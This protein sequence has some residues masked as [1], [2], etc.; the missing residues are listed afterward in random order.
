MTS[1]F[2][3]RITNKMTD[4]SI[5]IVSYRGWTRLTGCLDSLKSLAGAGFRY[6]VIIVDNH[7][8]EDIIHKIE[9]Q[10]PD[11]RF[12]HNRINGGYANGNNLGGKNATGQYLLVLNPDTVITASS[13]ERLLE[14]AWSNPDY[15]IISCR[16]VNETG[17]E[18]RA[19]GQF[20]RFRNMTGFQRSILALITRKTDRNHSG[21]SVSYPDW[22]SGSVILIKREL[23]I[24]MGGF[25][26]GYWM[27]FED[28]ELCKRVFD[29]GG[30]IAFLNDV[31]I[32]H[33]HGGSSRINL[34][35]ASITKTEVLV[36][37][38]VY[39]SRNLKGAEREFIQIFLVINNLISGAVMAITGIVLFFIP[40]VFIRT[41]IYGRL[42]GYYI[43][44]LFRGSWLSRRAVRSLNTHN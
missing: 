21:S 28:M 17:K 26:E 20:L 23:Y 14:T 12:I 27:Y 9:K 43:G 30:R 32:E 31:T 13:V 15:S 36:S 34:L 25:F 1:G 10:Y 37:R 33:N 44:S 3:D 29:E 7:S 41:I 5:I 42:I 22:V 19:A 16:Q 11:F 4:L 38:H 18:V 2:I 39:V 35:T 6:E 24:R 8:A 40:E